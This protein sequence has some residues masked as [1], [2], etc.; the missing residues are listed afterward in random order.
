MVS[1]GFFRPD[2]LEWLSELY[3]RQKDPKNTHGRFSLSHRNPFSW[4]KDGPVTCGSAIKLL[5]DS[6]GGK[7]LL[8]SSEQSWGGGSGQQVVTMAPNADAEHTTLWLVREGHGDP[9]CEAGTPI[10]CNSKI[11]LTHLTTQKN[12]HTH[13]VRSAITRQQEV[14]GFGEGG[15][16]DSSE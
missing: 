3:R 7:Y 10:R 9:Q 14:S 16:G 11:R 12:L 4:E 6:S 1:E 13:G 5:H 15:E 8:S 2:L